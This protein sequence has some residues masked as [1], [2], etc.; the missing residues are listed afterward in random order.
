LEMM[1]SIIFGSICVLI[2]AVLLPLG[3]HK[4]DE[5]HVGVY[6]RGGALLGPSS[7][8]RPG[9]H[10]KSPITS[11]RNIQITMQTDQVKNIPCGT[12]GGVVLY[13]DKIEVVNRL[14]EQFVYETIKNYT[15]NYD[16]TWVFDKIHHSI[17]EFCS[18]HTLQ[19]VYIDKFST[20]DESLAKALQIVCNVWAPGI[21]IIAIRVTKP[22]IPESIR[23][24]FEGIEAEKT[25]LLIATQTQKVVE[26]EAQTERKRAVIEAEKQ[27]AVSK[28]TAEKNISEKESRKNMSSI[29][30]AVHLAREKA[31]TDAQYYKAEKEAQGNK[32]LFTQPYLQ[33]EKIR[34]L[35]ANSQIVYGNKIPLSF[36]PSGSMNLS[37]TSNTNPT[38]ST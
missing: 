26:K 16:Q 27:A 6:W 4:V 30:D 9:Y 24:N 31:F 33:L 14:K 20:L 12:S 36:F 21:E 34:S 29:E 37:S 1:N 35:V 25:K 19:E 11:F 7:I 38:S 15:V 18:V 5:G 8:T 28:I 3:L 22:R 23:Q 10:W 2:V 32:L 13:F 17:N